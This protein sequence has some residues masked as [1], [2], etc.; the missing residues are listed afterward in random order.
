HETMQPDSA[1]YYFARAAENSKEGSASRELN[2]ADVLLIDNNIEEAMK[3]LIEAEKIGG[4]ELGVNNTLGLIYLGEYGTAYTDLEK[5]LVYNKK[6]HDADK[7]ETTLSVLARNYYELDQLDEALTLFNQLVSRNPM[8][9]DFYYLVGACAFEMEDSV[10][11]E[12]A[13]NKAIALD[14]SYAEV[15]EE[16][17]AI[18]TYNEMFD[19]VAEEELVTE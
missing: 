5:A 9:P 11:S 14:S 10:Q 16:Y 15:V 17:K 1:R 4:E 3:H 19:E 12:I 7:S 2:A 8:N 13:F 18:M 6:A